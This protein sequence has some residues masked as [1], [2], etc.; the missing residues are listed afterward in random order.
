MM[1]CCCPDCSLQMCSQAPAAAILSCKQ[2]SLFIGQARHGI[3]KEAC[4]HLDKP[5]LPLMLAVRYKAHGIG[6]SLQ[7]T[8][9]LLEHL[10]GIVP[11]FP[12]VVNPA[13]QP[14]RA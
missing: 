6:H 9:S 3:N 5:R 4:S 12:V 1:M 8:R 13:A 7:A 14:K 10:E 2:A 11:P